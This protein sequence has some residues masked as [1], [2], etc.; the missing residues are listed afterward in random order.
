M[1]KIFLAAFA[2]IFNFSG[3]TAPAQLSWKALP[4][5]PVNSRHDDGYFINENL[6]WVVGRGI[7]SKTTDG[8]NSWTEQFNKGTIYFRS[9]GFFDSLTGVACNLG[10]NEFGGQTDTNLIYRTT[11]GGASWNPIN[12]FIG[13]KPRGICGVSVVNDSMIVG[14][15]RV[16]GPVY[17]LKS[18]D[19]GE[20][21]ISKNMSSYSV[22]LM[23][24][25]FFS[26][27]TGFAVGGNKAPNQTSNGIILFT[28]DG[29]ETWTNVFTSSQT[30][31]WCW[32]IDFPSR[33]T[34]YVSLQRDTGKVVNFVKTTDGGKTWHEKFLR[35][36]GY[37]VQGIGFI[38]DLVGWA[39]GNS[40]Y[41]SLE[42]TDGGETWHNANF[43]VR[44]NRFRRINDSVTFATG[45]TIYK[46]QN[47]ST[48]SAVKKEAAAAKGYELKQNYPNPFNPS[49]IIEF[50]IPPEIKNNSLVLV[51]VYN[52]AGQEI[53]TIYDEVK[54]PGNFKI[55]FD[56]GGLPSGTYYYEL[57]TEDLKIT[58]KMLYIK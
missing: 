54:E 20:T 9:I 7:I 13:T 1:K 6:G 32:K 57:I 34:G 46:Y 36:N 11:N 48:A 28:T 10:T 3:N 42:T 18:T 23:D 16:R 40:T 31:E 5:A 27:D 41:T 49:T 22:D 14:V 17:F 51:K 4:N 43:G 19:K 33:N 44:V 38:N 8:G 15:G 12:N 55:R 2:V 25:H 56:A 39:G 37:Y 35:S 58:K 53:R 26:P 47:W 52:S 45:Q 30:G 21:W 24:V 29:G 50:T